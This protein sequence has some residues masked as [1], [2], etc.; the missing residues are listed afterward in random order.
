MPVH[1]SGTAAVESSF[2]VTWYIGARKNGSPWINLTASAYKLD[3]TIKHVINLILF[4]HAVDADSGQGQ[5]LARAMWVAAV[6][7]LTPVPEAPPF[8]E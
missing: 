8:T 4:A 5:E 7:R 2:Q 6:A 3:E 1:I